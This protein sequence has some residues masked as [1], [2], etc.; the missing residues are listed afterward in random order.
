MSRF[1]CVLALLCAAAASRAELRDPTAPPA[2]LQG[3]A[4]DEAAA[5]PLVLQG[6]VRNGPHPLALIN[7]RRVHPGDRIDGAQLLSIRADAVLIERQGQR[8][9]LRLAPS[10][11]K[12]SR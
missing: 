10:I 4:V 7:G 2:G 9:W 8:Q 1:L 12:P 5:A 6:V 11:L 3:P